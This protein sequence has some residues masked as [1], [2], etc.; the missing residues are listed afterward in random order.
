M[1]ENKAAVYLCGSMTGLTHDEI[2][3]YY[4]ETVA[5]LPEWMTPIAPLRD[6][7]IL[8]NAGRLT[9]HEDGNVMLSARGIFSR[10]KF[11]VSRADAVFANFTRAR[12]VSIG[13]MYELAWAESHGK[14]IV[15]VMDKD[16]F[17][18]HPFVQA[19]TPFIFDHDQVDLAI[20]TLTSILRKGL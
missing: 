16:G 1:V 13:S 2:A 11:D 3:D 17:H 6:K 19:S 7:E 18:D 12:R 5:R 15:V 9:G 4:A 20:R 10:D 14:P 8:K